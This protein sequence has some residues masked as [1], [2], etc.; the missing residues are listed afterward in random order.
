MSNFLKTREEKEVLKKISGYAPL[1]INIHMKI[2]GRTKR[3]KL[4]PVTAEE[5][6]IGQ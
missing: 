3:T 4:F 5:R 6:A 1:H 2:Q